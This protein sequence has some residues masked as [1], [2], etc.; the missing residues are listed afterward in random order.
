MLAVKLQDVPEWIGVGGVLI[1]ALAYWSGRLDARRS[2]ASAVHAVAERF[3]VGG[4]RPEIDVKVYNGSDRPVFDVLVCVWSWPGRRRWWWRAVTYG[5]WLSG[6]RQQEMGTHAIRE[7][8]ASDL[9]EFRRFPAECIHDRGRT[10]RPPIL[11]VFTDG[12]GRRWVRWPDGRLSRF[13]PSRG[14]GRLKSFRQRRRA[15]LG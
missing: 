9:M 13:H 4:D 10:F 3:E 2:L 11:V 8:G 14:F 6:A 12:N 5:R 7:H 1:A 15:S